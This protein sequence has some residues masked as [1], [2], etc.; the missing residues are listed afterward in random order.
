M[1][2]AIAAAVG[3]CAVVAVTG[4]TGVTGVTVA[5]VVA[6][7]VAVLE[8]AIVAV[9]TLAE[10]VLTVAAVVL[11]LVVVAGLDVDIVQDE[12]RQIRA[13]A[14][15]G[16][17]GVADH[18]AVGVACTNHECKAG[19]QIADDTRVTDLTD[20]RQVNENHVI[21]SLDGSDEFLHIGG[22]Q[23]LRGVGGDLTAGDDVEVLVT[24]VSAVDLIVG[25]D[26]GQQVAQAV[27]LIVQAED[28]VDHGATEVTVH[29]KDLLVHL[30]EGDGHVGND[31]RL[32]RADVGGGDTV[33]RALLTLG[34]VAHIGTQGLEGLG[35]GEGGLLVQQTTL[36][37]TVG[38][39]VTAIGVGGVLSSLEVIV[40]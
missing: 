2:A 1:S 31:Q 22:S 3:V 29:Q 5:V 11:I 4:V 12:A 30:G 7:V 35:D 21:L 32:T 14:F 27:D 15:H 13:K 24:A 26:T 36:V 8:V 40:P 23:K 9:L 37:V 20:R 33:N 25:A 34:G 10:A 18:T 6:L 17:H 38:H 19:H 28:L 16:F 39:Q